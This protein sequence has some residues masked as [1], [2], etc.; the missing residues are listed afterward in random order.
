[1][2]KESREREAARPLASRALLSSFSSAE[3]VERRR[4]NGDSAPR[5]PDVSG[6]DEGTLSTRA[7]HGEDP[8]V[9]GGASYPCFSNLK[10]PGG[11]TP[12]RQAAGQGGRENEASGAA[13]SS[14][15]R[16]VS[17]YDDVDGSSSLRRPSSSASL[18]SHFAAYRLSAQPSSAPC[19]LSKAAAPA[20]LSPRL[21]GGGTEG[22]AACVVTQSAPAAAAAFPAFA[23]FSTSAAAASLSCGARKTRREGGGKKRTG[24]HKQ[25]RWVSH[26]LLVAALRRCMYESG[27]DLTDTDGGGPGSVVEPPRTS[28]WQLLQMNAA[29]YEAFRK[30]KEDLLLGRRAG[31]KK[32]RPHAHEG[33]RDEAAES[34]EAEAGGGAGGAEGDEEESRGVNRLARKAEQERRR[35]QH[36]LK[37]NRNQQRHLLVL[38]REQKL[39]G[40]TRARDEDKERER[41]SHTTAASPLSSGDSAASGV[42]NPADDKGSSTPSCSL[43]EQQALLRYLRSQEEYLI[44]EILRDQERADCFARGVYASRGGRG[45]GQLR[46]SVQ[47]LRG[48]RA[49]FRSVRSLVAD[50]AYLQGFLGTLEAQLLASWDSLNWREASRDAKAERNSS[51]GDDDADEVPQSS[52]AELGDARSGPEQSPSAAGQSQ[53]PSPEKEDKGQGVDAEEEWVDAGEGAK[54]GELVRGFVRVLMFRATGQEE[55]ACATQGGL[56]FKFMTEVR[57]ADLTGSEACTLQRFLESRRSCRA[58]ATQLLSGSEEPAE[59]LERANPSPAEVS[60]SGAARLAPGGEPRAADGLFVVWGLDGL[61]RKLTHGLVALLDDLVSFSVSLEREEFP[62]LTK[63]NGRAAER[64]AGRVACEGRGA[65]N[66]VSGSADAPGSA[67]ARR[68]RRN[69]KSQ[70]EEKA[71]VIARRGSGSHRGMHLAGPPL[72]SPAAELIKAIGVPYKRTRGQQEL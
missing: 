62:E 36:K 16:R 11:C 43:E 22:E 38:I 18:S 69:R 68:P 31:K 33:D 20:S 9:A 52:S 40:G 12:P 28:C 70:G 54:K 30:G 51:A 1:M 66:D 34:E 2:R 50:S 32:G 27:E 19:V 35:K 61:Q 49:S 57:V 71:V 56:G 58:Q 7:G 65:D 14:L 72:F 45:R 24:K 47:L 15:Q 3:D 4:V 39:G 46:P 17:W 53:Q 6:E 42:G 10:K 25:R 37:Q 60:L 21:P 59:A 44:A 63:K 67:G 48:V 55:D 13:C 26:Q 29:A 23:P 41:S 8:R 64:L 5:Q